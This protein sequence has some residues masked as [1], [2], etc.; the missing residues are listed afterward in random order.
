M[1][2]TTVVS[3]PESLPQYPH[4]R[5]LELRAIEHVYKTL[6]GE[7]TPFE[8]H[9]NLTNALFLFATEACQV[10][11]SHGSIS[12]TLEEA[13]WSD[14]QIKLLLTHH[15][16]YCAQIRSELSQRCPKFNS[17]QDV[18]WELVFEK[19]RGPVYR[20]TIQTD[21]D[22]VSFE[23][24][25]GQLSD[26]VSQLQSANFSVN[27]IAS[28]FVMYATDSQDIYTACKE[29]DD[30]F[31]RQWLS[32]AENDVNRGSHYLTIPFHIRHSLS[33]HLSPS[34]HPNP[35]SHLHDLIGAGALVAMSNKY[36]ETPL[37]RAKDALKEKLTEKAVKTG[38]TLETIPFK[39]D[40]KKKKRA[41]LDLYCRQPEIDFRTITVGERIGSGSVGE[42]Y[43][44]TWGR[45]A[46]CIKKLRNQ[47]LSTQQ[48]KQFN[49]EVPKLR[50][51]TH[52]NILPVIGMCSHP[53][54]IAVISE[55]IPSGTMANFIH[56]AEEWF[57]ALL[58]PLSPH[59]YIMRCFPATNGFKI[60]E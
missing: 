57:S 25:P 36:G 52:L 40:A 58:D 56:K 42:I 35:N 16:T 23:C 47:N 9:K 22:H 19:S 41:N 27:K 60:D 17:V 15:T 7:T 3:V 1:E 39:E 50:L 11:A 37:N 38:Q 46:V 53:P 13:G 18:K 34:L 4:R 10:N 5:S 28:Q 2:I 30:T 21:G 44:G 49:E 45:Y 55:F 51:F 43:H 20:I 48:L 12:R 54:N 59:P 29:G 14:E 31:V 26:L 24:N 33:P 8:G 32:R 6:T